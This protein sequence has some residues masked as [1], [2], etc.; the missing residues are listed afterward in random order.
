[1]TDEEIDKIAESFARV[2]ITQARYILEHGHDIE[3]YQ[4]DDRINDL[5]EIP[6]LP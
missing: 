1:M 3:T 6:V 2:L 5:S 4:G